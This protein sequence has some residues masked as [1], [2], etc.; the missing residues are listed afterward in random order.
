MSSFS[1][2]PPNPG[3]SCVEQQQQRNTKQNK[4][5][6]NINANPNIGVRMTDYQFQGGALYVIHAHTDVCSGTQ[7]L[8][9]DSTYPKPRGRDNTEAAPRARKRA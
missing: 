9:L 1:L 7:Q 2:E 8:L 5:N 6:P 3:L 4:T